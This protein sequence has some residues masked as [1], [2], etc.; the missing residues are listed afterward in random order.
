MNID[1]DENTTFIMACME[2]QR[3][4]DAV[5]TKELELLMGCSTMKDTVF[6]HEDIN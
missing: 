4:D 5:L 3:D 1:N 6:V 2:S